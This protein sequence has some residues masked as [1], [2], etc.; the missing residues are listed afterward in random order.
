M[1]LPKPCHLA[2]GSHIRYGIGL[3]QVTTYSNPDERDKYLESICD[4]IIS[5]Y[6]T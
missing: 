6:T 3:E 4:H 1:V 2:A 5:K